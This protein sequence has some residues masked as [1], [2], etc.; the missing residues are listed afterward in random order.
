[1]STIVSTEEATMFSVE[2]ECREFLFFAII[3]Y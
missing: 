3:I 1:M 2:I